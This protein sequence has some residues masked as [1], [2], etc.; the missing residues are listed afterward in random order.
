M[1]VQ[2]HTGL[3]DDKR[4][5]RRQ[6]IGPAPAR[7]LD[8]R[9]LRRRAAD[10][11]ARGIAASTASRGS[12]SRSSP[13]S[14]CSASSSTTTSSWR[15]RCRSGTRSA[16]GRISCTSCCRWGS[17]ST[18]SRPSPTR[19]TSIAARFAARRSLLDVATYVCFF[20]Q[21]VA[22]PIERA[23]ALLPQFERPRRLDGDGRARRRHADGGRL[24]QEDGA[25]GR[26]RAGRRRDLPRSVVGR[27]PPRARACSAASRSSCRSTATSPATATSRAAWRALFGIR[28]MV[29]FR[30]PYLARR[31]S[32]RSSTAGTSA[33]PPGCATTCSSRSA[34]AAAARPRRCATCSSRWWSRG[35]GT[36][37][38]GRSRCGAP[39][40]GALL[41]I[42]RLLPLGDSA[43]WSWPAQLLG[44]ARHVPRLVLGGDLLP[45]ARP[46]HRVRDAGIA[47]D[48]ELVMARARLRARARALRAGLP[49]GRTCAE[50]SSHPDA[51]G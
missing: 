14:G 41:V 33:C 29:N 43:R 23:S 17:R 12:R 50:E 8:P 38:R 20:P 51:D 9:R 27:G 28:L 46:R 13:R 40:S 35:S 4:C 10:P 22:G 25:R 26:D 7:L 15:A 16:G 3:R 30:Q 36:A 34:A 31:V 44:I 18:R 32:R 45:R 48:G 42:D 1:P 21:L 24:L 47:R 11:G 6:C 39:W 37:R 19:S 5:D 49:R 2:H